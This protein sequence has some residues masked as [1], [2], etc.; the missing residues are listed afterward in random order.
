MSGTAVST[1]GDGFIRCRTASLPGSPAL[2]YVLARYELGKYS[3]DQFA[4]HAIAFPP[5][6]S[7]SVAKRQAEF[8][9]GRLCARLALEALGHEGSDVATGSHRQ[10]IWP[11]GLVG[12]ITHSGEYAAALVRPGTA[13]HGVGIDI[14]RRVDDGGRQALSELAVTRD[15]A[16]FL[17][18]HAGML[19]FDWLLTVVFSAK[20]SFFKAAFAQ[21]GEFFDFDAVRVSRIDIPGGTIDMACTRTL[22]PHLLQGQVCAAHVEFLDGASVLTAV[23]L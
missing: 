14:E 23:R 13:R 21:V 11:A 2:P 10:P 9:A 12:S 4:R 15:E 6:I 22:S 19:D 7:K 18:G 17:R 5:H 8:L 16:A 3:C 20:E 1:A